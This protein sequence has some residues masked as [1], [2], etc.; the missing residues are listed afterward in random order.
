MPRGA[1][2]PVSNFSCQL[3]AVPKVASRIAAGRTRTIIAAV[4]AAMPQP[5]CDSTER[6]R[7]A[8]S[9]TNKVETSRT[10]SD[11]LNRRKSET[12]VMP[13]LATAMPNTV[14]AIRPASAMARLDSEA[15]VRMS[16][17]SIG[18]FRN[19][20]TRSRPKLHLTSTPAPIPSA[21]ESATPP[22]STP[23]TPAPVWLPARAS[24]VSAVRIA[25]TGSFTIASQRRNE[26]VRRCRRAC[27]SRGS[28][29]VG[30]VTTVIAPN[31]TAAPQLNPAIQWLATVPSTQLI[32]N[33]TAVSRS[34]PSP[35]ARRSRKLSERPPSNTT[36]ATARP[37]SGRSAG[38][39]A[40]EGW[41]SCNPGPTASPTANS[42]TM[43]GTL[44]RQASHWLTDPAGGD[45]QHRDS[46]VHFHSLASSL[47][48]G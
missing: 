27:R 38:P 8:V 47:V 4:S 41:I 20:G 2:H 26:A 13:R 1:T 22:T 16:A 29:T 39:S 9:V 31:R 35:A 48:R 46:H 40:A 28:T 34:T 30:P 5:T 36:I 37:T 6:S 42:R 14:A 19:S 7:S 15:M 45:A 17:S 32:G 21:A 3:M 10:T 44:N 24:S 23:A 25:P 11:S 33:A 43:A 18:V 12:P